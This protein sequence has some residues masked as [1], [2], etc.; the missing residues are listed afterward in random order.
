MSYTKFA[1]DL[2]GAIKLRVQELG[3]ELK[4]ETAVGKAKRM[5]AVAQAQAERGWKLRQEAGSAVR[6]T[7]T[8]LCRLLDEKIAEIKTNL[9]LQN[10]ALEQYVVRTSL[11][12]LR[13]HPRFEPTEVAQILVETYDGRLLFRDESRTHMYLPGDGPQRIFN[14]PYHFDYNAAY[15]WC[16]REDK[17]GEFLTTESLSELVL[18]A[19]LE[20]HRRV[21]GGEIVRRSRQLKSGT[22]WS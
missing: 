11:A 7:W 16:W 5:K 19:L 21:G 14:R 4:V 9:E 15:G 13:L 12:S 3:G 18:K 6:V 22:E 20:T 17:S 2:V 8:E 10:E 1:Q